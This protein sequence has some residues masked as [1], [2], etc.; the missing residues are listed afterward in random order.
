MI[1]EECQ[2]LMFWCPPLLVG[3]RSFSRTEFSHVL[4]SYIEFWEMPGTEVEGPARQRA[5][6]NFR[7]SVWYCSIALHW[8]CRHL[9]LRSLKFFF[10]AESSL[11]AFR[12]EEGG[13]L[14]CTRWVIYWVAWLQCR[15]S[16]DASLFSTSP[17]HVLSSLESSSHLSLHGAPASSKSVISCPSTFWLPACSW[18]FSAGATFWAILFTFVILWHFIPLCHFRCV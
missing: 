8:D 13:L 10:T 11:Y 5:G 14:G 1:C 6:F 16:E 9:T 3:H 17:S 7:F 4:P 15:L 12:V 18:H 2:V